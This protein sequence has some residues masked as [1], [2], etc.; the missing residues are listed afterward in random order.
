MHAGLMIYHG[1]IYSVE[2]RIEPFASHILQN[3]IM[4]MTMNFQYTDTESMR[5]ACG[6]ISDMASFLPSEVAKKT[7]ELIPL[8]R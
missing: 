2:E 1:L 4:A 6:L 5:Y 8:I 7:N 3:L